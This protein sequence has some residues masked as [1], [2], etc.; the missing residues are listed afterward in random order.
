MFFSGIVRDQNKDKRRV[1]TGNF[2]GGQATPET[3]REGVALCLVDVKIVANMF[4][5][6]TF[7]RP[8]DF[9]V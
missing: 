8:S 2:S 7:I 6:T 9:C 4:T 5:I 3:L 1:N